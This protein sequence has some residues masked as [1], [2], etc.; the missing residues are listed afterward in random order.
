MLRR[1]P[2]EPFGPHAH[3][4]FELVLVT[5]GAALHVSGGQSWPICAGDVFVI[6]GSRP[7]DY[8]RLNGLRLI[9][10][11]FDP[12]R[13]QLNWHDLPKLPGYHALMKLQPARRRRG[14]FDSRLRLSARELQAALALVDQLADE[15]LARQAGFGLMATALFMRLIGHLSRC[16]SRS[17]DPDARALLRIGSAL[18]HLETH[19]GQAILL[20]DLATLA[21]MSRRSFQ[22]AFH[23]ATGASPIR[24]LLELRLHRAADLLRQTLAPITQ[25]GFDAGFTDSNYFTRQFTRLMGDCPRNYRLRHRAR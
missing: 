16:Y 7:H 17:S 25:V 23:A 21:G 5:G 6:G 15:L 19:S 18:S 3:E 14:G 11:L 1:D 10:I 12:R 22:R 20:D 4:F 2:Q 13:L 8:Q 9:N 24:Y